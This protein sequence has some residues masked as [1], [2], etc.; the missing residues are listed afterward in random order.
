MSEAVF[1]KYKRWFHICVTQMFRIDFA[2]ICEQTA[3]L[4]AI[5]TAISYI[6]QNN[7]PS[8]MSSAPKEMRKSR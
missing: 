5:K 3:E 7:T 8:K 2:S 6:Q 1:C 4:V